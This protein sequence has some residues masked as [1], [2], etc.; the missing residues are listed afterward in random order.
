MLVQFALFDDF[1]VNL[2]LGLWSIWLRLGLFF[3][4]AS[5]IKVFMYFKELLVFNIGV[6]VHIIEMLEVT[7]V[8]S[9]VG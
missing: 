9:L 6:K 2:G 3:V 5:E 4:K 8:C 1:F 7:D